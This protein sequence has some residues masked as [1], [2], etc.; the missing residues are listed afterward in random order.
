MGKDDCKWSGFPKRMDL[1]WFA[2]LRTDIS[3]HALNCVR[4]Y[5]G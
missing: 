5:S 2:A 1:T 4:L 3:T